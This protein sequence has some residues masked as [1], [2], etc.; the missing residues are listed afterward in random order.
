[1]VM[2]VLN[3]DMVLCGYQLPTDVSTFCFYI[4]IWNICKG[5]MGPH[6]NDNA[7]VHNLPF[8]LQQISDGLNGCDYI[9]FNDVPLKMLLA[10]CR[11]NL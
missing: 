5:T 9:S 4:G 7:Y 8:P 1:M 3:T 11:H 2:R 6:Y 10:L